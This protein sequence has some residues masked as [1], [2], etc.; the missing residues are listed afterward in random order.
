MNLCLLY[1]LF[2]KISMFT[3]G[4]GYAMIPLFQDELVVKGNSF[5]RQSSPILSPSRK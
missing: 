4:G 5:Q 1:W 3:F 2:A